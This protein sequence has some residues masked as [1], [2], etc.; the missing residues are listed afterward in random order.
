MLR[1]KVERLQTVDDAK[2]LLQ[3]AMQVELTTLPPYLYAQLTIAPGTNQ[4]ARERVR[5]VALEEMIH[6]C[7]VCNILNALGGAPLI[8]DAK[9]APGYPGAMPG[10]I[11]SADGKPFIVRLL[12][13]SRDA[14]K[15]GMDIEEPEDGPIEPPLRASPDDEPAS[16]TIGA[17]YHQLDAYLATLPAS[18]WTAGR[19]QLTDDQF[20]AGELFP[21]NGYPDAHKA[22]ER[23]VS[24]GEGSHKDPL[25]FE[26]ELAHFYRFEEI[27]LDRV[28][29]SADNEVGY[30]WGEPL[31]VSWAAVLP[32]IPDP[33]LHDF[34]QDPP[35]RAA[36]EACD[37]AYTS[38][39]IELQRAVNGEAGRLGNAVR[40]MFDLRQASI[41]ALTIPLAGT[42]QVAG[43]AFRFR[44]ELL[45]GGPV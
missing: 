44:P 11:G 34:S 18:A 35:A 17:F 13:F 43:P 2:R 25:D 19:N 4:P 29:T 21:V 28:L 8:A 1:L 30:V 41:R 7:L 14:M 24:Q 45:E 31:G 40:A 10:G 27:Y 15:Q 36:Q 20:F 38:M 23:I 3:L 9:V 22:I 16:T 33:G 39:L 32:A 6:M 5:S 37:L 42:A 26:Q 12:P